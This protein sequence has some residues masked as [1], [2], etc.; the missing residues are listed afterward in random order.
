MLKLPQK[1]ITVMNLSLLPNVQKPDNTNK[2][3]KAYKQAYNVHGALVIQN[4]YCCTVV[5]F[6]RNSLNNMKTYGNLFPNQQLD[7]N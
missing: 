4:H 5:L 3:I 7:W 6:E 2:R 1:N